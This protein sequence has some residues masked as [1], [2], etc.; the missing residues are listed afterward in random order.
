LLAVL[1]TRVAAEV[2]FKFACAGVPGF[3]PKMKVKGGEDIRGTAMNAVVQTCSGGRRDPKR[4]VRSAPIYRPN[5]GAMRRSVRRCKFRKDVHAGVLGTSA[6]RGP[7]GCARSCWRIGVGLED[8]GRHTQP[9][10]HEDSAIAR[11]TESS[12]EMWHNGIARQDPRPP[13][14]A[15]Y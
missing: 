10:H 9:E 15:T 8:G 2:L 4:H 11:V 14:I 3:R 12:E 6:G 7:S 13:G 1:R 5:I